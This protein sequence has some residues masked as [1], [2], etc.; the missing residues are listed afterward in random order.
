M[1][2]FVSCG[3]ISGD[4]I[5][6]GFLDELKKISSDLDLYGV[7]GPYSKSRGVKEIKIEHFGSFGLP[8]AKSLIN[9]ISLLINIVKELRRNPPDAMVLCDY[10]E[11]NYNLVKFAP[12]VPIYWISPPQ[13]WVWRKYRL[14]NLK[15][16]LL[17]GALMLPF[18]EEIW[19]DVKK[20]RFFGNPLAYLAAMQKWNPKDKRIAFFPGSRES[21]IS[22]LS[23]VINSLGKKLKS[24]DPNFELI[25]AKVLSDE[26]IKKYLDVSLFEFKTNSYEVLATSQAAVIK[27][28]SSAIE[29]A[30]I[31]VPF[32]VIYKVPKLTELIARAILHIRDISIPNILIRGSVQELIQD[33]CNSEL[34]LNSV[35]NLIRNPETVVL[36]KIRSILVPQ[37][38]NPLRD[39]ALHFLNLLEN[40]KG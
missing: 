37:N 9:H 13:I 28:G 40:P 27:S 18:E 26:I 3:E 35:L 14:K 11:F 21:E 34:L 10:A 5:L 29:A 38:C 7:V 17:G 22:L 4:K 2:L 32:V 20:F 15:V 16:R 36:N 33:R 24:I 12:R 1:R 19:S 8:S 39:I 6:A 31:G 25:V 30:V 23:P